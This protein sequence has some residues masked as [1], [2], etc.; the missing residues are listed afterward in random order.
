MKQSLYKPHLQKPF[1]S[2]DLCFDL[3]GT[4]VDTAP[5]LIRV[6]N[7]TIAQLGVGPTQYKIARTE[8]G[9]GSKALIKNA[10]SRAGKEISDARLAEL[11][12]F[13]LDRYAETI[14]ENSQ[15]FPHVLSTLRHLHSAG[16]RLT[17]C[18]NKPGYLA[19]PLL[20]ALDMEKFFQKIVGGD[21]VISAKPNAGHIFTAAG[22]PRAGRRMIMVGDS[23]P[24]IRAAHNAGIP[25]ILMTYGY[26]RD[27]P[28]KLSPSL[29]LDNFR[30]IP[31]SLS[32]T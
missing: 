14:C 1:A 24:D 22:K 20:Q 9:F 3:D 11:R 17:V 15:P 21:E 13:F 25:S 19:R 5:D 6:T 32:Q 29:I 7:E 28:C 2:L 30:D 18:T 23:Y 26:T 27:K 31:N 16:A 4:L 8:V 10:L 12:A